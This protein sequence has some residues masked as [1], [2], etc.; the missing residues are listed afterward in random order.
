[1][2]SPLALVSLPIM[3]SAD[4][5]AT[6]GASAS[7][8]SRRR[9]RQTGH[10]RRRRRRRSAPN[11]TSSPTLRGLRDERNHCPVCDKWT[12]LHRTQAPLTI[13][14]KPVSDWTHTSLIEPWSPS[15]VGIESSNF[16]FFIYVLVEKRRNCFQLRLDEATKCEVLSGS[17]YRRTHT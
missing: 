1:M 8:S 15:L 3:R 13:P 2:S 12:Y 11:K 17:R 9:R 5:C 4:Q 7:W 14:R 10:P 16:W 6:S